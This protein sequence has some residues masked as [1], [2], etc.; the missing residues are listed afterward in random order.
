MRGSPR[1]IVTCFLVLQFSLFSAG[2]V[3]AMTMPTEALSHAGMARDVSGM[4]MEHHC[5]TEQKKQC[6]CAGCAC[7]PLILVAA[8]QPVFPS[9]MFDHFFSD[10]DSRFYRLPLVPPSRPP[11]L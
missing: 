6:R 2:D 11:I 7:V 10:P 1:V 9:E 4:G 5:Q 3:W 8:V